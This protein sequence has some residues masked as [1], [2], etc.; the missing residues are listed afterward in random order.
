MI[1]EK[2]MSS[3]WLSNTWLVGDRPGG[4]AVVID[5][6]GPIE[7]IFEKLREHRLTLTHVLCTH[8]HIDHVMHNGA[9]KDE[10]GCPI[11]GHGAEKELFGDLDLEL[12]EGEELASGDLRIRPLHLPGHTAGQLGFLVNGTDVFTGDTLFKGS[13]GGTRA[14]GHTNFEELHASI[15][16]KLMR[17]PKETRVHPGHTDSTTIAQEWE[18]N[19]FIRTFRGVERQGDQRVLAFGQPATLL[20]RAEDYDGGTKAWVRFDEGEQLDVVPGS[21]V[22]PV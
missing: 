18:D 9:Y 22:E 3:K 15:M 12:A 8:H 6:G 20:C 11:C 5:T 7:P 10:F 14:P 4:H 1:L 19:P 17:L 13:I 21:R 16:D 2:T